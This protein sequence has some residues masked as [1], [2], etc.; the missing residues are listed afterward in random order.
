[1]HYSSVGEEIKDRTRV[2]FQFYPAGEVPEQVLI[3]RHVGDSFDTLDIRAGEDNARSDGY[4]VLP[5]PTQVT[6]LPAAH[7][8]PR[9]PH[10]RRGDLSRAAG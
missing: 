3:S 4:Y 7:A 1:M 6:G 2:G 5:E 10:V 8:H 9:R